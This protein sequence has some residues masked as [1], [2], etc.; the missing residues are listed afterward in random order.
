MSL[1][2]KLT[3]LI[4]S[5]TLLGLVLGFILLTLTDVRAMRGALRR[6][7]DLSARLAAEYCAAPLA[8]GY[9]EETSEALS[10]LAAL[11]DIVYAAVYDSE[12]RLFACYTCD[13]GK[14]SPPS[15]M[16]PEKKERTFAGLISVREP[17]VYNGRVH[18]TL[19]LA[20]ST[21]NLYR[22]I[23][24]R[25]AALSGIGFALAL[26]TLLFAFKAHKVV[27]GPMLKL[28][29]LARE[30]ARSGDY[31]V[32][33]GISLNDEIGAL[34]AGMDAMLGNL[35]ERGRERDAAEEALMRANAGMERAVAERTAELKAA[36]E[37]LE[38]FTYSASHDLRAPLRR[39]DGFAAVLEE[40]HAAALPE[41]ARNAIARIRAGCRQMAGVIDSLL[42]LSRLMRQSLTRVPLDLTA[43]A[44][45]T[46][47]HLREAEPERAVSFSAAPGLAAFG[48]RTLI[49]EVLE[50]LIGNAWKF[51][52]RTAEA[53]VEFGSADKDGGTAFFVRDNG[54]GFDMEYAGNLFRPFQR[55]HATSDFPGT[56]IG[57][58]TCRRIIERHDGRIRAEGQPGKG[59]TFYFTLP[60][61]KGRGRGDEKERIPERDKE[62][63][64]GKENA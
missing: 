10:K 26:L 5:V 4:M 54:A 37:E 51:T 36:N 15:V 48:D 60:A 20:V 49:G 19:Y 63:K 40:D 50:N 24:G 12:G 46:A 8:F 33:T 61:G 17:M 23:A 55:L 31:S 41:D 16:P 6:E 7:A 64:D 38:A 34:A 43:M 59:A 47:S 18:G 13:G 45:E 44:E 14:G 35:E 1:R 21:R 39:M 27:S 25:L 22:A 42:K 52:R 9:A 53:K 58:V 56:G 28:S 57:L 3:A 62:G 2:T 30:V 11:D 29:E 32:R